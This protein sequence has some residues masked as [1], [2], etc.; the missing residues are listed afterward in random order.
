VTDL[1]FHEDTGEVVIEAEKPGMVIGR[2][3]STLR[4]ITQKVGWTPRSFG[5]PRSNPPPSRTC[6]AS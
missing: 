2:R 3:G 5:R 4:E 1:D 6:A